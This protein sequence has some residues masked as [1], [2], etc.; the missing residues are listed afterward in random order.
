MLTKDDIKNIDSI[1]TKRI[2]SELNPV[3]SGIS[4]ITND[5]LSIKKDIVQV[6]KDQKI[7]V[8]AFDRDYLDLRERIERLESHLELPPLS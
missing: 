3:K 2:R 5:I 7:I 1:V 6:R 8:N 4:N